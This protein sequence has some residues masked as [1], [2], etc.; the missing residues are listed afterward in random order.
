MFFYSWIFTLWQKKFSKG[1]SVAVLDFTSP[2]R[3]SL[4]PPAHRSPRA[5][6]QEDTQRGWLP[7]F[8][9]DLF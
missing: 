6:L 8:S 1:I 2:L 5:A 7:D 9:S 4:V 3:G